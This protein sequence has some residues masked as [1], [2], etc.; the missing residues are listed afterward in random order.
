MAASSKISHA[1]LTKISKYHITY[2]TSHLYSIY[3]LEYQGN[4][5]MVVEGHELTELTYWV[6]IHFYCTMYTHK[7]QWTTREMLR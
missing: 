7:V 3:V 1:R 6:P 4:N 5:N 2:V